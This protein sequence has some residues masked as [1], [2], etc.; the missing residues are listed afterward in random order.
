[1]LNGP[2]GSDHWDWTA[3]EPMVLRFEPMGLG[4]DGAPGQN[5]LF[6]ERLCAGGGH[7]RLLCEVRGDEV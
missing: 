2:G 5:V 1:M 3:R 4:Q 6:M 7:K